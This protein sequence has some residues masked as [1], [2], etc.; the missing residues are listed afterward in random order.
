MNRDF[1]ISIAG[2]ILS[3]YFGLRVTHKKIR[4]CALRKKYKDSYTYIIALWNASARTIDIQDIS[5]LWLHCDE[6]AKIKV[7]YSSDDESLLDIRK[8]PHLK[9]DYRLFIDFMLKGQGYL[10]RIDENIKVNEKTK[11]KRIEPVYLVGR[12][13]AEIKKSMEDSMDASY[14]KTSLFAVLGLFLAIVFT[15]W[16]YI[17]GIKSLMHNLV[18]I[19]FDICALI[20]I[21]YYVLKRF[22]PKKIGKVYKTYIKDGYTEVALNKKKKRRKQLRGKAVEQ[23]KAAKQE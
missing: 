10:I 13:R 1:I 15:L 14:R 16:D 9:K 21:G 12:L 5:Y 23:E 11:K 3:V 17:T 22:I 7:V 2:I 4:Y 19:S 6:D 20:S 8:T 18:I